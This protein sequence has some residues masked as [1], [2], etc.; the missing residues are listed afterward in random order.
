MVFVKIFIFFYR[1]KLYLQ[2]FQFKVRRI[3]GVVVLRW[4]DNQEYIF[5]RKRFWEWLVVK[6]F[7]RDWREIGLEQ[8]LWLGKGVQ[9]RGIMYGLNSM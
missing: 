9:V 1:L 7:S 3:V 6:G 4:L 8:N 5:S 2:F